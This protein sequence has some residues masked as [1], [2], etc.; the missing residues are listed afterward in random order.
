MKNKFVKFFANIAE[1]T[2]KLSYAKRL[3]VGAIL[4]KDGRIQSIGY[5]GTPSGF[6][7]K[8]ENDEG[9]TTDDVIHAEENAIL[10]MAK[11]NDSSV[12]SV[13]F[14]THSPC[15]HC[16]RLIYLAGISKVYY[17]NDYRSNDGLDFLQKVKLDYTKVERS[18]LNEH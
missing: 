7:N 17:I 11:S 12:G 13:L 6:D 15:I 4:V 9:K 1:E 14:V 2:A 16:A 8:C 18:E 10:K 3:Q 5:N